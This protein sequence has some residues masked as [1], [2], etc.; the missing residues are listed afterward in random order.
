M[1]LWQDKL[2]FRVMASFSN[3]THLEVVLTLKACMAGLLRVCEE[4]IEC[5]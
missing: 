2:R 4:A 1:Q 3:F 5:T